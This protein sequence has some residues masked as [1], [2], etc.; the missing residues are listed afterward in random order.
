V[1]AYTPNDPADNTAFLE[2]L[3]EKTRSIPK[4][5]IVLGDWNMVEDAVDRLPHH[6]DGGAVTEA[7]RNLK[8]KLKLVNG[9]RQTYPDTKGY[10]FLQSATGSQS[11]IDRILVTDKIFQH[12]SDW[13]I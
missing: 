9:W 10:S 3:E 7:M 12:S 5:D 11:R 4:P 13:T 1:A 2:K 8:R 6:R